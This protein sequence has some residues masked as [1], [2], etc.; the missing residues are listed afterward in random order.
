MALVNRYLGKFSP[1]GK[2]EGF[3]LEGV[4]YKTK[5]EKAAKMNEGYVELTQ[6][7]WEYYTNNRGSG[8]NGTGYIR[9]PRTGKPK[10]APARVYTKMELADMAKGIYEG[11]INEL[12]NEIVRMKA[13]E[14]DEAVEEIMEE[15]QQ[16]LA[17]YAQVL[18]KIE[19]GQITKPEQ[20]QP[21]EEGE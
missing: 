11:M 9:D 21:A 15:K 8:D 10:S 12:D 20:I 16:V 19:N 2:P 5:E 13:L 18:E 7:E 6:E 1:E 17:D 14:N 3:L 4:N